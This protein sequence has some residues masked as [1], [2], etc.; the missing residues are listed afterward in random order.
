KGRMVVELPRHIPIPDPRNLPAF[1]IFFDFVQGKIEPYRGI[2]V[3][4]AAILEYVKGAMALEPK[5]SSAFLSYF[6]R[7]LDHTDHEIAD[8]ALLEFAKID[9]RD[10]PSWAKRLPADKIAGWLEEPNLPPA[11]VRLYAP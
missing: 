2:P 8:D 4:S 5:K 6:F 9:Y 10:V 3:K 11:R 1:L 7:R